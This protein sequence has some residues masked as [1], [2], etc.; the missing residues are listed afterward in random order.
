MEWL[1]GSDSPLLT[2][3]PELLLGSLLPWSESPSTHRSG[4]CLLTSNN[5]FQLLCLILWR[6]LGFVCPPRGPGGQARLGRMAG[7]GSGYG[8]WAPWDPPFSMSRA[9]SLSSLK[10]NFLFSTLYGRNGGML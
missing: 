7:G 3:S 6:E 10:G 9:P 5:R 2:S 8:S 1:Q 4:R